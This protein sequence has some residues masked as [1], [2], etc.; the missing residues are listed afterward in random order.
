MGARPKRSTLSAL[1]LIDE[2]VRTAWKGKRKNGNVVSMLS[3]DIS[4]AYPNTL[5]ERLLYILQQKGFPE[6]VVQV[7]KGF[8]EGQTTRLVA[9]GLTSQEVN[10]KTGIPQGSP[11]SPILFLLFSSELLEILESRDTRGSAF[12]DDT[13]I[14]TVSP[15]VAANY[16]RLEEAHNKCLA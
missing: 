2:I 14:L 12:V 6:W 3:L 11:L 15:S 9:G 1:E 16:R 8:I 5:Y 7:T 13:N 4:G 10:I